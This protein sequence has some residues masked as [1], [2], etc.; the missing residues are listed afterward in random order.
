MEIIAIPLARV[1]SALDVQG[2]DP[3][4]KTSTSEGMKLLGERYGFE[5]IPQ[6]IDEID[7]T[8]GAELAAGK[9][10]EIVIDRFTFY[11]SAVMIDTHASTTDSQAVLD[12]FMALIRDDLGAVV[13]PTR[14]LL[15][16]HIVF[17]SELR[18]PSIHPVLQDVSSIVAA[19]VS[20]SIGQPIQ[21]ELTAFGLNTDFSQ[22]RLQ[23]SGF[24]IERRGETP[25]PA[26]TYFSVAPV[27]TEEH[28]DLLA[29]CEKALS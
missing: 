8:K 27:S 2:I 14:Q 7:L 19:S 23:P 22:I 6:R 4:G 9:F 25:F 16:S 12:D 28:L 21:Y 24:T 26:N 13:T 11:W 5:K 1:I 10:G 18:L 20:K 17:R 29:M 3:Q 15:V